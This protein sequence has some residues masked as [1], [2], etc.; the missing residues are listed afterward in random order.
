MLQVPVRGLVE[1]LDL[2]LGVFG[3]KPEAQEIA[4]EVM[5]PVPLPSRV[6]GHQ[7]HGF[8][9]QFL[10]HALDIAGPGQM[11]DQV[12]VH[13]VRDRHLEQYLAPIVRLRLEHLFAEVVGDEPVGATELG[14][15]VDRILLKP[16]RHARQLQTCSPSLGPVDEGGHA[17]G[18]QGLAG[19]AFEQHSGVRVV[20]GEVDLADLRDVQ[21]HP[22]SAPGNREV[23][24]GREDQ[25]DVGWQHFGQSGQIGDERGVRQVVKILEHDDHLRK[26]GH[27]HGEVVDKGIAKSLTV[28][29]RQRAH[30]EKE[31]VDLGQAVQKPSA[32]PHGVIVARDD[33][34]PDEPQLGVRLR[35]LGQED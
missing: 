30:V 23:C 22:L 24:P 28:H 34:D 26:L 32:E 17:V 1:Q 20:E 31:R 4:E 5:E 21:P 33:L 8:P 25:V 12:G 7:E 9:L 2:E 6:E 19:N 11:A 3:P 16:E 27:L 13:L 35:P 14:H 29:G 15:E 10:E 18:A